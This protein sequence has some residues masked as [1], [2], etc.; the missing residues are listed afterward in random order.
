MFANYKAVG[1][2]GNDPGGFCFVYFKLKASKRR[3]TDCNLLVRIFS[4]V[5]N[6]KETLYS[7]FAEKCKKNVITHTQPP[8]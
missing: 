8:F 3:Y 2:T 5:L 6:S 7:N 1:S 4:F